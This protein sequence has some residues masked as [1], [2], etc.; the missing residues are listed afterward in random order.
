MS[1]EQT[2]F[3]AIFP[4]N[5][6]VLCGLFLQVEQ[7]SAETETTLRQLMAK[8]KSMQRSA[9]LLPGRV[10]SALM[11]RPYMAA[12]S[13]PSNLSQDRPNV[14]NCI[15]R[16]VR[17][18]MPRMGLAYDMELQKRLQVMHTCSYIVLQ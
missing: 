2:S 14:P 10:L 16:F 12:R 8:D 11:E 3:N 13:W 1:A 18:F 15:V 7:F 6:R 4:N 17:R 5:L 9:E